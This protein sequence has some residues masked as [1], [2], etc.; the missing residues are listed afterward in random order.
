MI[1]LGIL[2]ML[3]ASCWLVAKKKNEDFWIND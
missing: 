3:V 2:L 1:E